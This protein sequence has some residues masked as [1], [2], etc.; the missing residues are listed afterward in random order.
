M[1]GYMLVFRSLDTG[2][3]FSVAG[4]EHEG[5]MP[6]EHLKETFPSFSPEP[7]S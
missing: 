1:T 6:C 5:E 3:A 4:A 7:H 2:H